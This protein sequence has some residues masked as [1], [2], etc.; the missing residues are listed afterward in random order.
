MLMT[1]STRLALVAAVL[2]SGLAALPLTGLPSTRLDWRAY[3][4][5]YRD[6]PVADVELVSK[7][8]APDPVLAGEP[9]TYTITVRNNGPATAT[10]VELTDVL[11]VGVR[12]LR[13]TCPG[14]RDVSQQAP[15]EGAGFRISY[16]VNDLAKGATATVTLTVISQTAVLLMNTAS[17]R[18]RE[19]DP[20]PANNSNAASP[21]RTSVVN[22]AQFTSEIITAV[23][24]LVRSDDLTAQQA[25]ALAARLQAAR[26]AI[27]RG[28]RLAAA[29]QLRAFVNDVYGLPDTDGSL[30]SEQRAEL[31]MQAE[32]LLRQ[33][34]PS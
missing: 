27:E 26:A 14:C 25:A 21:V 29:D 7:T 18:A 11:P 19:P 9:L 10:G 34:D 12:I 5:P 22:Q 24:A 16:G 28:D 17:V 23:G 33:L 15:S 6:A 4:D 3:A 31:R 32:R 13:F 1:N 8:A 30:S 2:L 20:N